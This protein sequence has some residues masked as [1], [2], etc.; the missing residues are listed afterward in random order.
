MICHTMSDK[1]L[2][3]NILD[4][5]RDGVITLDER[6]KISAFNPAMESIS[7][8]SA[9]QALGKDLYS[10]LPELSSFKEKI[11]QARRNGETFSDSDAYMHKKRGRHIRASLMISPLMDDAGRNVGVVIVIRDKSQVEEL[12]KSD[13]H[14]ERVNSFR[15]V[16]SS[17]VHEIKNPM[18]GIRGAAQLLQDQPSGNQIKEF[19]RVIIDEVDR[20]TRLLDDLSNLFDAGELQLE[21]VNIHQ[22]LDDVMILETTRVKDKGINTL[23]NFDPSIPEIPADRRKLVQLFINVIRNSYEAMPQGGTI[24]LSSKISH[25]FRVTHSGRRQ[26]PSRMLMVMVEDTG[27]GIPQEDLDKIFTPYYTSK[28]EGSGLGLAI[29]LKI[30][31]Q[32]GG[33]IMIENRPQGG[34]AVKVFIPLEISSRDRFERV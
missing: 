10:V 7:E 21:K 22:V 25:Q 34:T 31:E 8:I 18:G 11:E 3:K 28:E 14:A 30:A 9:G 24:T 23:F 16:S 33:R 19:S 5:L 6:G 26:A 2:F 27:V 4:S 13:R 29:A 20:V 32:H 12:L 17:I 15:F 1:Q